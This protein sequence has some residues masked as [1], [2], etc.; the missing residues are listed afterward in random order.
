MS[1]AVAAAPDQAAR[2]LE[3]TGVRGGLI[4]HV[5]CGAGELTAALGA[6]ESFLVHGLDTDA[7]QVAEARERLQ[8]RRLYGRVSVGPFDGERLPY[9]DNLVNLLVVEAP[10]RLTEG[11]MMRVL[12]PRG[13]AYIRRQ[14]GWEKTVKPRP[15]EI[16]EWTHY[17]HSASNNAVG[18]D[19][20]VG[21]PRRLQW[22]CGPTWLRS[23]DH[24]SSFSAMV[25]TR[26]RVFY[27]VDEGPVAS[28]A[29]PS[30]WRLV[31]RDAFS[32]VR[33]WTRPIPA[34]ESRF[35]GFRSGPPELARRLVAVDDR[36]YVTLGYGEPVSALDAASGET[37][38]EY[39][40]TA[41]AEELVVHDGVLYAVVGDP[42]A[43][44][45]PR[46]AQWRGTEPA[47]EKSI[48]AVR[49]ENGNV[50][51]NVSAQ[52]AGYV[53][54]TTLAVSGG[55]AF[56]QNAHDVVCRDAVS[57][58]EQWRSPRPI[59]RRRPTWLAPTLT[60][61]DGVVLSGDRNAA[62]VQ[63]VGLVD[64]SP[65]EGDGV[66]WDR[67][68]KE[69]Y[70][71]AVDG[72]PKALERM[73]GTLYALSA[74]TGEKLWEGP[75]SETFNG[76]PDVLVS[77]GLVWTTRIVSA[78]QPGVTEGRDLRTGE[79]KFTRPADQ[80]F[81]TVGMGHGRCHRSFATSQYLITG[82]AGI[83]FADLA[84]GKGIAD[85]WIRGACQYGFMPANGLLYV[86]PHPCAC[87]IEA[88][89]NGFN[90][91]APLGEGDPQPHT[92]AVENPRVR[93]PAYGEVSS[94]SQTS[95]DWP[96]YRQDA[97]R[98]GKA[99]CSVPVDVDTLW[100][101]SLEGPLSS[102]V[103][104][105][106]RVLVAAVDAHTVHALEAESGEHAWSFTAGGRVDSP[107]T[108]HAGRVLFGSADGWV[109]CLRAAD[110]ELA[111]RFRA[112]PEARWIVNMEQL[113]SAWPIHGSVLVRQGTAYFVAGRSSYVDGGMHL[114]GL[115]AKTGD[116]LF[117]RRLSYRDPETGRQPYEQIRGTGGL[118]GVLPDIL[119]SDGQSLFLR[120]QR[121]DMQGEK[122]PSNVPHL[123][124]SVGFLDAEWWHRTYWIIGTQTGS[125]FGG[126]RRPGNQVPSGRLLVR[127]GSDVYGFGRNV[128]QAH[129]QGGGG[130]AGLGGIH[131]ELFATR[132]E[133]NKHSPRW[134]TRLPFWAR[135]MVLDDRNR[136]FAAGPPVEKYLSTEP[137]DDVS[138]P[139]VL[140]RDPLGPWYGE[141]FLSLRRPEEAL[142]AYRG[143]RG[144]T[145]WVVSGESGQKLAA[146]PLDSPPVFD[147]MIAAA[148][149]LYVVTQDGRVL[150]LGA[151]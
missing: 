114:Y 74:E 125:G 131:Y 129:G 112:A 24:L 109:Y 9:A 149:R 16:D 36:V 40:A 101:S 98:N 148:D 12:A 95:S 86:P 97:A 2:I 136:L 108:V 41:G 66:Q 51:W 49:A 35:R 102:P 67:D 146:Y 26:D 130:H 111:W 83:E 28:V 76:P 56:Y 138:D 115:N 132:V 81:Y 25:S 151:K 91:M 113:E 104:G 103:V 13:V 85:H 121:Y 1:E 58:R 20:A 46:R 27:I 69:A 14:G 142:Q 11:E 124:S 31:A 78:T 94:S 23:H 84:S 47:E 71:E 34:W 107:P 137:V 150:C 64:E 68:S 54:P 62:W 79:V 52:E 96:T 57:G 135:A 99:P 89:I 139:D 133:G 88:K 145:L 119:S 80:E 87:Y 10:G 18:R 17:L 65:V 33:L 21:P 122:Q 73:T 44:D 77:G 92:V 128:Y 45:A 29:F 117:H 147:G 144:G 61:H 5:G 90:V 37:V 32:G 19:S 8:S 116:M 105:E 100:Q 82:R 42:D 59:I 123:Y 75:V 30:D 3:E 60:V 134:K 93:G 15:E 72:R 126:W 106:G 22:R 110:G 48:V 141:Y 118:P 143:A 38:R 70:R 63:R 120:H 4:V 43:G 53:M 6:D 127:D 50:L 7:D 140:E 55:K 39:A